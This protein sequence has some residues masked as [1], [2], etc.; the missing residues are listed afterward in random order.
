MDPSSLQTIWFVLLGVIWCLYLVL[1][2][3]D[4]G[5]GMLVRRT[6][7]DLALRAIGPTWGANEVWLILAVAGT[8]GAFPIW[9][10]TWTEALYVPLVVLV[11]AIMVRH[12]AIELL[13]HTGPKNRDRAAAAIV[14]SSVITAFGWGVFW[15]ASLTGALV[16][17]S[18]DGVGVL[19]PAT[20]LAGVAFVLLCRL[21][22]TAFLRLRIPALRGDLPLMPVGASAGIVFAVTAAVLVVDAAQGVSLS[23]PVAAGFALLGFLGLALLPFFIRGNWDGRVLAAGASM[24]S[25][26]FGLLLAALFPNPI[27]GP[28]GVNLAQAAAGDATLSWMLAIAVILLPGLLFALA[29]AYLRFLRTPELALRSGRPGWLNRISKGFLGDPE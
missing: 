13:G 7:R 18:G 5:V 28:G 24:V 20:T 23:G 12:A 1:G 8:L 27:A 14:I 26:G 9:Y 11:G 2:G 29:F 21:M 25:G 17:P 10:A 19:T 15:A 16:D 6:D 3:T 22:G 4:L